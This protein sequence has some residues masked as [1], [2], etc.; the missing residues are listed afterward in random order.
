MI[1]SKPARTPRWRGVFG[2]LSTLA[3]ASALSACSPRSTT[4]DTGA[5]DAPSPPEDIVALDS[6]VEDAPD[7]IADAGDSAADALAADSLSD[8][9]AA[10]VATSDGARV[11]GDG[12]D[13]DGGVAGPPFVPP[14]FTLPDINPNSMTHRMDVS[15][16]A[17]RGRITA[18]YFGTAT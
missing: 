4:T 18:W 1:A 9:L 8:A 10:D 17:M 7:A 11:I 12:G 5:Q 15:P 3:I 14:D 13:S 2:L 16:R 6:A